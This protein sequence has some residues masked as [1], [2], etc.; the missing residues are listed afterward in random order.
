MRTAVWH[1]S[2]AAIVTVAILTVA[3]TAHAQTRGGAYG[4]QTTWWNAGIGLLFTWEE[5][6]ENNEGQVG[7]ENK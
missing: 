7:V 5:D 3:A 2:A 1:A 4:A 6:Y